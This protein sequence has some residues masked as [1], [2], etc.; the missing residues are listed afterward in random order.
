[1]NRTAT[2]LC[3][4]LSIE[5]AGEPKLSLVCNC[6]NCQRRTG[7]AFSASAY[8]AKDSIIRQS[9]DYQNFS[10]AADSGQSLTSSFC[11]SCGSTVF[12]E[13]EQFKGLVGIAV[14]CFNDPKFPEPTFAAWN[15]SKFDWVEFPEHWLKMD[16]Q[17]P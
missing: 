12:W 10:G 17:E 16:K 4:Q 13:A 6:T 9:G 11:G 2:C 7:S 1:M 15:C 14:G 3:G 5:V 8:F